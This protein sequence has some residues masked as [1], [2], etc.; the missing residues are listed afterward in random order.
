MSFYHTETI[1][2]NKL[3]ML[4]IPNPFNNLNIFYPNIYI[5]S[6]SVNIYASNSVTQP[7]QLLDMVLSKENTNI[8]GHDSFFIVPRYIY[9]TQNSGTS[10]EI[11]LGGLG[12][13][14]LGEFGD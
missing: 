3:Y 10:T 7:V 9:V 8:D 4:N 5:N 1:E 11:I 2:L 6:G 12:I 14:D 13:T